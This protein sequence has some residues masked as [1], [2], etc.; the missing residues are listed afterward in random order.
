[1]NWVS[2]GSIGLSHNKFLAKIAS[3]L[4]KP[5]GFS[6]IGQAETQQVSKRQTRK[7]DLGGGWYDTRCVGARWNTPVF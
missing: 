4:D 2:G 7:P 1:M 5:Q 3:D 6:V